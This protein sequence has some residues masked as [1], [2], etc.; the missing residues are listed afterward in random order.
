MQ[1][2]KDA[3]AALLEQGRGRGRG[4]EQAGHLGEAVPDTL[5]DVSLRT[6][7]SL[8]VSVSG[9]GGLTSSSLLQSRHD[10]SRSEYGEDAPVHIPMPVAAA[11]HTPSTPRHLVDDDPGATFSGVVARLM[12]ELAQEKAAHMRTALELQGSQAESAG[13]RARFEAAQQLGTAAGRRANAAQVEAEIERGAAPVV[14]GFVA[15]QVAR[16]AT[17]SGVAAVVHAAL[18]AA[19]EAEAGEGAARER[20]Q[21]PPPAQQVQGGEDADATVGMLTARLAESTV[22]L[23]TAQDQLD[24]ADRLAAMLAKSTVQLLKAYEML[25]ASPGAR[26]PAAADISL[27]QGLG[28]DQ[29]RQQPGRVAFASTSTPRAA[30]PTT[31]TTPATPVPHRSGQRQQRPRS[32]LSMGLA[33]GGT[34]GAGESRASPGQAAPPFNGAA[35]TVDGQGVV[36]RL[37]SMHTG[38]LAKI[39]SLQEG[40]VAQEARARKDTHAHSPRGAAGQ[41]SA[42]RLRELGAD[43]A[44]AR[45]TALERALEAARSKCA[46]LA[47]ASRAHQERI[48]QLEEAGHGAARKEAPANEQHGGDKVAVMRRELAVASAQLVDAEAGFKLVTA[49]GAAADSHAQRTIAALES[50]VATLSAEAAS[51]NA[52]A[53]RALQAASMAVTAPARSWL[54]AE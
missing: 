11:D 5:D 10:Y 40:V 41:E 12:R 27:L 30:T 32:K 18:A 13:I 39:R 21:Q 20:G 3:R 19:A 2:S 22:H 46:A 1:D 31:P 35:G 7:Q 34:N 26:T 33:A 4:R 45:A 16:D 37:A 6:N 28:S 43:A 47:D 9:G 8:S 53:T 38:L 23:I 15:R 50:Q 44:E 51:A 48:R 49:Q 14:R 29:P 54:D 25:G 24:L 17:H 42:R 52:A 36:H